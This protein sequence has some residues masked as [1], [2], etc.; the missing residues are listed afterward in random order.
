M[1][2]VVDRNVVMRRMTVYQFRALSEDVRLG[3][4]SESPYTEIFRADFVT[5]RESIRIMAMCVQRPF[6]IILP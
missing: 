5:D 1:Q 2:S 4:N 6:P 3:T